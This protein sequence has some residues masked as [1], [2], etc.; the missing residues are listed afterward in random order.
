MNVI[1][2][3]TLA[4][5]MCLVH[6]LVACD[7]SGDDVD[8]LQ[9]PAVTIDNVTV[10]QAVEGTF[11]VA[12]TATDDVGVDFVELL[13]D[14]QV[15]ASG[16]EAPFGIPWDTTAS[17]S[18]IVS[19]AARVTDLAG[20]TAE[21]EP[22]KVVVVNGGEASELLEGNDGEIAIPEDYDGTQEIHVKHHWTSGSEGAS[23]VIA[24]LTWAVPEEQDPWELKIDIGSGFCPHTGTTYA[25]SETLD[26]SP[27]EFDAVP[28]G[29][30]PADTQLFVHVSPMNPFDHLGESLAYQVLIFTF[31]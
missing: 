7:D 20:K 16:E 19:I 18:G 23:R 29:G 30:F 6:V 3:I 8:D 17:P 12:V 15:A 11:E 26:A 13:V 25:T 24:I 4:V 2:I 27:I 31:E 5:A 28:D 10:Y 1:R 14:G 9:N 21:S 22:I